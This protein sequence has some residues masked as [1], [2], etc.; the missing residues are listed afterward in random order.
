MLKTDHILKG[1]YTVMYKTEQAL[2]EYRYNKS[3]FVRWTM[4]KHLTMQS[5]E[6]TTVLKECL[7]EILEDKSIST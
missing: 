1:V 3:M 2:K 7:L 6:G 4:G 5:N